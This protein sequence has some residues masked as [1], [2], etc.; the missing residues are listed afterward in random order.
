[1]GYIL[2][3]LNSRRQLEKLD[4]I[5]SSETETR[6][7]QD[8]VAKLLFQPNPA[9]ITSFCCSYF[10]SP[11]TNPPGFI[12]NVASLLEI[13]VQAKRLVGYRLQA[14]GNTNGKLFAQKVRWADK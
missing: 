6:T 12:A 7:H 5:K 14:L 1:M 11:P 9:L 4:Q 13:M 8:S 3:C 10:L 2:T